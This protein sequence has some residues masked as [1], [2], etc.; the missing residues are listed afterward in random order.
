MHI[1][2]YKFGSDNE[3]GKVIFDRL[4]ECGV[5]IE[6]RVWMLTAYGHTVRER[7]VNVSPMPRIIDKPPPHNEIARDFVAIVRAGFK[8]PVLP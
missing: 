6:R 8:L 3:R 5:D 2:D 1:V 7:F 4:K